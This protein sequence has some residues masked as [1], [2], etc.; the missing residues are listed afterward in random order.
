MI[1]TIENFACWN[2][3]YF[4]PDAAGAGVVVVGQLNPTALARLQII[5]QIGAVA[6]LGE[7]QKIRLELSVADAF[8]CA[9]ES[10]AALSFLTPG[11]SATNGSSSALIASEIGEAKPL[12]IYQ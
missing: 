8:S 9:F 5:W 10:S 4:Y 2:F 6:A 7:V 3:K 12:W 1:K 11:G